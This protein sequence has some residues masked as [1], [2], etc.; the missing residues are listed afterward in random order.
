MALLY[1]HKVDLYTLYVVKIGFVV[2]VSFFFF[3]KI[4]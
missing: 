1:L 2:T 4:W 3:K